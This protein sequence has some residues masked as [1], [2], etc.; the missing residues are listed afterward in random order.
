MFRS[1]T[2][3]SWFSYLTKAISLGLILPKV[4]IS[5]SQDEVTFWL[6]A[7]S[8]SSLSILVDFGF[9]P[10]FIRHISQRNNKKEIASI[11]RKIYTRCTFIYFFILASIGTLVIF[12]SVEVTAESSMSWGWLVVCQSIMMYGK[13]YEVILRGA[14]KI[15][16]LNNMDSITNLF[17]ALALLIVVYFFSSLFTLIFV[18][19]GVW[20][21]ILIRNKYLCARY[22]QLDNDLEVGYNYQSILNDSWKTGVMSISSHLIVNMSGVL[23]SLFIK[24]DSLNAFLVSMKI[25]QVV[26][27]ISW[28]PFY[29]KL[30]L[31]NKLRVNASVEVFANESLRYLNRSVY[32][33]LI[34]MFSLCILVY[35]NNNF[36]FFDVNLQP[37]TFFI[38]LTISYYCERMSSMHAQI[39]MT[40][41]KIPFYKTY[42]INAL[43]FL[44]SLIVFSNDY[45]ALAYPISILISQLIINLPFNIYWSLKSL[46]ISCK[47]YV[48]K[49]CSF[50]FLIIVFTMGV[51]YAVEIK[52]YT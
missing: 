7:L 17:V 37:L 34:G 18:S 8:I 9:S 20:L 6:L 15:A 16:M 12:S 2:I 35:T 23:M 33:L 27:Q 43:I 25:I 11:V 41:N 13:Y 30:P 44:L 3:T 5:F 46:S 10:T 29:S 14:N 49:Y 51:Y 19:Q 45:G 31:L 52:K 32:V 47:Y 36:L 24:G 4:L 21:C 39:Y 50:H 28:A 48:F 40:T 26:N 42:P 1:T 22:V 38:L